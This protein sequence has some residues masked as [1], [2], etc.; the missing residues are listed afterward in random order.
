MSLI[1]R[2]YL[3]KILSDTKIHHIEKSV[4]VRDIE[5]AIHNC[6]EYVNLKLFVSSVLKSEKFKEI[7]KLTRQVHVVN[8]LRTKF[9]MNMNILESKK[10]VLNIFRRKM[11]FTLCE[12]FEINIRVTFKS[13]TKV[14]R[15]VLVENLFTVSIKSIVSIF[16]MMKDICLSKRD[17]LFQLISR[18]LNLE[19]IENVM[20]HIIDVNFI[21]VQICNFTN[22]LIVVSRKAR[23]D[24][25]IEYEKHECYSIDA[26]EFSLVVESF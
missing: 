11:I 18:E 21:A 25:L 15:V 6:F 2:A 14:D 8:N 16:I 10:I 3:L 17:Y 13:I 19:R 22:K 24:R 7:A 4:I 26:T 12:R 20:T 9:F 5:I 23:L 1:D